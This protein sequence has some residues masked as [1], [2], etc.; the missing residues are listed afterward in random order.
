MFV[1]YSHWGGLQTR[2]PSLAANNAIAHQDRL[3]LKFET[4]LVLTT[5]SP[6][7]LA[8]NNEHCT[9][10]DGYQNFAHVDT[11]HIGNH[12]V[13]QSYEGDTLTLVSHVLDIRY[14]AE[15]RY[16]CASSLADNIDNYRDS[17]LWVLVSR[18][19]KLEAISPTRCR[20][21]RFTY[22]PLHLTTALINIRG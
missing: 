21:A 22:E 1:G 2:P 17:P 10:I 8:A 15:E 5:T 18:S 7:S 16:E 12:R 4:L 13:Y 19:E 20:R 9:L 11:S 3:I 14:P 6:H